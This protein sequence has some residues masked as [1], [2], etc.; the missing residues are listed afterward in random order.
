MNFFNPVPPTYFIHVQNDR[1]LNIENY[2]EVISKIQND[3]FHLGGALLTDNR[4]I[5]LSVAI[6]ARPTPKYMCENFNKWY[7][8]S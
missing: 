3:A 2:S 4:T 6:P 5:K 1:L 7:S 8:K